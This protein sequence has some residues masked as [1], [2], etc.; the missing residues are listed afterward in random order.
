MCKLSGLVTEGDWTS[1]NASDFVPYL[2][3]VLEAFG[4]DRLM[5]GSDWPVCTIAADYHSTM[6][7]VTQWSKQL[8][9]EEQSLIMGDTCAYFYSV[10]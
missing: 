7:I 4:A 1:W 3:T 6:D 9:S 10:N 8:S 5:I 2:D